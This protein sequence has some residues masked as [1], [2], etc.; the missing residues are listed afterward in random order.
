MGCLFIACTFTL[1]DL[2]LQVVIIGMFIIA[3]TFFSVYTMAVDT[4]F[5]CFC[6]YLFIQWNL[7]EANQNLSN[8]NLLRI[9]FCVRNRQVFS[10]YRLN[11]Q[12]FSI[13]WLLKFVLVQNS[14]L[15]RFR[16]VT[17]FIY[18]YIYFEPLTNLNFEVLLNY[19]TVY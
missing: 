8:L 10:L 15:F 9:N 12:W 6:E 11:K 14:S 1:F 5:L 7:S 16:Q 4:L 3:C 18:I 19:Q 2:Y 17:L 13:L